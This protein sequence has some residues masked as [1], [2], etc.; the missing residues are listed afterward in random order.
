MGFLELR[1]QCG[2]SRE[3]PRGSQGASHAAP[4]KSGLHECGQADRVIA[5]DLPILQWA[6]LVVQTVKNMTVMQETRA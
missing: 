5:L 1:R 2:V 6:S 4:E 3:I